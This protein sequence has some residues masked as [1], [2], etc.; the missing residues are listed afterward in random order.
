MNSLDF[1]YWLQGF[2]ELSK[3]PQLKELDENQVQTIKYHLKL[4]FNKETPDNGNEEEK[5]NF[6]TCGISEPSSN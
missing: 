6:G 1:C 2:F 4:V 3:K 5:G